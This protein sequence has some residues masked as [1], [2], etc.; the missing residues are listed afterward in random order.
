M[1]TERRDA[2]VG[3]FGAPGDRAPEIADFEL[4]RFFARQR[5]EIMARIEAHETRRRVR[6]WLAAASAAAA[7]IAVAVLG[8]AGLSGPDTP[9]VGTAWLDVPVFAEPANDVADP[10]DAFGAWPA[11]ESASGSTEETE[12]LGILE[13][14]EP[15]S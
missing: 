12:S 14:D 13:W 3:D 7:G 1:S 6:G 4:E 11:E 15:L 5:R 9:E 10:L 2:H 8:V